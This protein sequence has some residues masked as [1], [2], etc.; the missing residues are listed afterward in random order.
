QTVPVPLT[1]THDHETPCVHR[2]GGLGNMKFASIRAGSPRAAMSR[3][4]SHFA[5]LC[6]LFGFSVLAFGQEATIVGTVTDP[7][8]SVLPNVT[9]TA[10]SLETG[11]SRA[12]T[13]SGTGEYVLPS[14]RIGH[15]NL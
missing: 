13:T 7:S 3:C 8:G 12:I 5:I 4:R 9:I 15:Y 11:Q 14:L 1:L 6:L 10:T 2:L